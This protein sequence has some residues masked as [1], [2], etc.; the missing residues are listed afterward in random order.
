MKRLLLSALLLIGSVFYSN[1]ENLPTK[2]SFSKP[3][4][5]LYETFKNPGAQYRPFVRWWWNGL[6]IDKNEIARELD[7]MKEIGIGGVE[8]NSIRFPDGADSLNYQSKPYLSDEWADMIS[9]T[10]DACRERGMICDMIGGS[11][12]PFGGEF[13]PRNQQLQMLTIETVKVDG[14]KTGTDFSIR[15]D[16][17]L[18]RVNP[19][20]AS[21]NEH[22]LKE[23]VY[24][25]LM[26][27]RVDEFTEGT[28]FDSLVNKDQITV[29]VPAGEHVIYFFV[30]MTGYMNV[31]NGAPGASGPVL[32]HF[33]KDAVLAYLSRL[34]DKVHFNDPS[35]KGKIRATFVDSFE[36]EG[37]NWCDGMLEKWEKYFGY[38]LYP[39]LPYI[40]KKIGHMGNPLPENYGSTFSEKIKKN[41]E[42]R[43]RNDF[44]RFQIYLF[45]EN[46]INTLNDWCRK[47][48]VQSRVQAYGRALHPLES[49]MYID[50]PECESWLWQDVGFK[51]TENRVIGEGHGFS[52]NNK[53]TASGSL[54]AGNGKVSCEE[55]TNTGNIYQSTLE[56]I[57]ITGDMSNI[58]GVNHSILHGFN[59]SPREAGFPGWVQYGDY[60]NEHNTF[61]PYY[62]YWMDYKARVSAILQNSIPQS[63]I[64]ILPPLE[65]MWSVLGQQRDPFPENI[66][67][68]Y[69]HDLWQNL[70]QNG[71]GCDYVSEH[72]LQQ[73]RIAK[74][75]LSF[76]PRTYQTLI[77]L[78]VE[79]L[80]PK[81]AVAVEQFVKKGGKVICIGKRPHQSIGFADYQ[82]KSL[83]VQSV[84][85]NLFETYPDRIVNIPAP[86]LP[87]TEWF[88]QVQKELDLKPYVKVDKPVK[89]MFYNYYKS[90]DK[91]IFFI[92]NFNRQASYQVNLSFTDAVQ[93]KQAW[94]WDAETGKRYLLD[95]DGSSMSLR[96]GPAESKFIVFDKLK[97]GEPYQ[98][99][100]LEPDSTRLIGE[101]WNVQ[102]NH[103]DGST[104]TFEIDSLVDF[105]TLPFVWMK[106]FAGT[107]SYTTTFQVDDPNAFRVINTGKARGVVEVY[108]NGE[109]IGTNWYGE[110][111][112]DIQHKLKPG[113]NQLQIKLVT[114]L[115]NYATTITRRYASSMEEIGLQGPVRMY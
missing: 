93:G 80:D 31:I 56:D 27:A 19:P 30:K 55:L 98:A 88:A 108:L 92:T 39:Y 63:D 76:G 52:C 111:V 112:F 7:L 100:P 49:S 13:L 114:P 47:N 110:A 29:Q 86:T 9:F 46:F 106:Y 34:S 14:G 74:G 38:S 102:A 97:T 87:Q 2:P 71:N 45:Q 24:I 42:Y 94:L 23:L 75:K 89:W 57:K 3:K 17:L 90:G 8:I 79:S 67:P 35:L 83:T 95:Q 40:I 60:F 61:W 28:S 5:D 37:A 81:T 33:N 21:K 36:L 73:A 91:D 105:N 104:Q 44:E 70:H 66:F 41:V 16:E 82:K 58:S 20:I 4:G 78:D 109:K 69:A 64:A 50:I 53:F 115:G 65:D 26:P 113:E 99:L 10:A 1:G 43:V 32:N 101:V 18:A 59:Y 107:L 11:G 6:K 68:A 96:F 25:R 72:I 77:L 54:L 85:D 15:K 84:F 51:L 48:G 103:V 22:P 62:H 12:W